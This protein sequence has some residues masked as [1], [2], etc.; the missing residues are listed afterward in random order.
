M[1]NRKKQEIEN[2]L[3]KEI[4]KILFDRGCPLHQYMD[5]KGTLLIEVDAEC[6]TVYLGEFKGVDL[7]K[8]LKEVLE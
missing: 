5:K 6:S 1:E 4:I 8:K 2:E 3:L 7:G